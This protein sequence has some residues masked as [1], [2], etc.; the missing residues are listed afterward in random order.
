MNDK[1]IGV[2]ASFLEKDA[3]ELADALKDLP[4]DA[5]ASELQKAL[6][7][8]SKAIFVDGKAEGKGF[9]KKIALEAKE[10]EI[11]E[12][13]GVE[14]DRLENMV[15]SIVQKKAE[16]FEGAKLT[17]EEIRQHEAYKTD[18]EKLQNSLE[19]I[20][21]E[22]ESLS[23]KYFRAKIDSELGPRIR[24]VLQDNKYLVPKNERVK[25]K[26]LTMLKDDLVD[27]DL[28]TLNLESVD[29]NERISILDKKENGV[30]RDDNLRPMSMES[31]ID[32]FAST[33]F[34][35]AKADDRKGSGARTDDKGGPGGSGS[36]TFKDAEDFRKKYRAAETREEK[37]RLAE[38]YKKQ[39]KES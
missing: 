6:K 17:P 39:K 27:N 18:I 36:T 13:Y 28:A 15:K 1:V 29:G 12:A 8:K 34:E 35:K 9:G 19:A 14:P 3:G 11:A 26:L 33:Y 4:E 2:L 38:E 30:L 21:G 32:Q 20:K 25:K 5:Q 24:K 16:E 31:Y 10:Q 22:K 37:D 7:A 23:S